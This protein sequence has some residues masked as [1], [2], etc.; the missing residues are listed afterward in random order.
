MNPKDAIL[1]QG[2][3]WPMIFKNIRMA[4]RI[5]PQMQLHTFTVAPFKDI[6]D[7]KSILGTNRSQ[8]KCTVCTEGTVCSE[9]GS[10]HEMVNCLKDDFMVYKWSK[11][12]LAL[13]MMTVIVKS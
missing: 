8:Q 7:C 3:E 10:G 11:Q 4:S 2:Q 9:T 1:Y 6:N 13:Y 12:I 5:T